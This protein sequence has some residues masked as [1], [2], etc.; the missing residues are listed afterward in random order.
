[1]Q[2]LW[3]MEKVTL[4]FPSDDLLWDFTQK[5][6]PLFTQIELHK[7]VLTCYCSEEQLARA[8]D[9]YRAELL[10]MDHST[11]D[12]HVISWSPFLQLFRIISGESAEVTA[13]HS[14]L[15]P[16]LAQHATLL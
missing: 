1:M 5:E 10:K 12:S 13:E 8:K 9:Q 4:L 3:N 15:F 16:L 14:A 6:K 7:K 11:W 2:Y